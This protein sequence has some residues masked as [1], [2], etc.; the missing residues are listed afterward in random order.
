MIGIGTTSGQ[1]QLCGTS[2]SGKVL[3]W[4]H[5]RKFMEVGVVH[6][7]LTLP[8]NKACTDAWSIQVH[9]STN[10]I[11]KDKSAKY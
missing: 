8:L 4:E 7:R 6:V 9:K 2:I 3:V 1:L 11:L 5:F 10:I